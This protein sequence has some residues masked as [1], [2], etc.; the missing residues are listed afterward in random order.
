MLRRSGWQRSLHVTVAA[1]T[2]AKPLR[3][4]QRSLHVT[5]TPSLPLC[6]ALAKSETNCIGM[7]FRAA[8]AVEQSNSEDEVY[9]IGFV[10]AWRVRVL[11]AYTNVESVGQ[12]FRGWLGLG[13]ELLHSRD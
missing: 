4:W 7:G 13:L 12:E 8:Q 6:R 3:G 10:S 1:E 5:Q 2:V 11:G 9:S